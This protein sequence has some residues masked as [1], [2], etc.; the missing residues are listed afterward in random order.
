MSSARAQADLR[1]V[2]NRHQLWVKLGFSARPSLSAAPGDP[3]VGQFGAAVIL[4]RFGETL[5][6]LLAFTSGE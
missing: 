5:P 6:D 1:G 4:G 3:E 2:M